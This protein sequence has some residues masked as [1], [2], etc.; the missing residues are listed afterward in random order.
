M[1]AATLPQKVVGG[2]SGT[3]VSSI[4]GIPVTKSMSRGFQIFVRFQILYPKYERKNIGM[5]MYATRKSVV[6]HCP[7][8][9][10]LKPLMRMKIVHQKI[11]HHERYGWRLL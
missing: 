10:T 6:L 1:I 9:N 5:L 3:S 7:G 11:P 8:K 2:T 4:V